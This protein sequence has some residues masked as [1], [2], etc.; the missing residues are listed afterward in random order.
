MFIAEL[1]SSVAIPVEDINDEMFPA[2]PALST[3]AAA[4]VCCVNL[5]QVMGTE[6]EAGF[7]ISVCRTLKSFHPTVRTVT[8]ALKTPRILKVF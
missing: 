3:H 2:S 7:K 5:W 8:S 4:T 6:P 1:D